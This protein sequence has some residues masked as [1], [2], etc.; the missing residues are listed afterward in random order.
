VVWAQSFNS[1]VGILVVRTRVLL[2]VPPTNFLKFQFLG[3]NSG[4][5]DKFTDALERTTKAGFNSSVGILVVRTKPT[6]SPPTNTN[7]FQFL[8]RNSGRSDVGVGVAPLPFFVFQFLGRNSGRSDVP[9]IA[10]RTSVIESFQFL[11]R[12]SGRSDRAAGDY[13]RPGL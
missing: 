13:H 3:R 1:S 4:R 11:G 7:P 8:G 2:F 12:N 6:S 5:S 9:V 10:V